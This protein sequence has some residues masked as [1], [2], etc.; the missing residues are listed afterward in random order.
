[1]QGW[2][3]P[4]LKPADIKTAVTHPIATPP[5]R[6]LARGKNEVVII[7]DD[8]TRV[9]RAEKNERRTFNAHHRML[10]VKTKQVFYSKFDVEASVILTSEF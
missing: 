8:M 9:T 5:L 6:D 2:D 4:P 3:R 7:F 10:N 1:M